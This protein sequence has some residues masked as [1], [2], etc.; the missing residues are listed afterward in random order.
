MPPAEP[1]SGLPPPLAAC[2]RG[3]LP[4]NVA[5]MQLV[6]ACAS[7]QELEAVLERAVTAFNSEAEAGRLRAARALWA[8]SPQAWNTLRA[9]LD[10]VAAENGRGPAT[11][12]GWT[13][14]FDR[15]AAIAPDAGVALYALG[16]NDLLQAA[17][18][19]I[20]AR[21]R[22]WG[23]LGPGRALLEI[24]C[25][26]GRFLAPLAAEA[27]IVIGSD[28]SFGMLRD[29]RRLL[30][31]AAL[32]RGS[33]R[34]L[35]AIKSICI[36]TVYAVDV[37]P[38]LVGAGDDLAPRHVAEAFRVLRSGGQLLILNY[39][40]RGDPARDRREVAGLADALGFDILQNGGGGL[41]HWDGEIYRLRKP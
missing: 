35:A 23:C 11:I 10:T 24:G 20:V 31:S 30:P 26:N 27:Q 5:L 2:A 36:D 9:V 3:D 29:A 4:A 18:L 33:G 19:E 37:F 28:I 7:R 22:D 25:G 15:L 14:V 17:T 38:Y 16:R 39:S 12:G 6:Q 8:A 13:T 34:D 32:L 1:P 21:I 40:Y 41:R